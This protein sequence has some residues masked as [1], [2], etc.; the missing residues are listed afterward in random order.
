V[1]E[2]EESRATCHRAYEFALILIS[3]VS[4]SLYAVH[5][6]IGR[7]HWIVVLIHDLPRDG[8]DEF[9]M[10]ILGEWKPFSQALEGGKVHG[11]LPNPLRK[12][13]WYFQ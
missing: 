13:F 11:I 10:L 7:D 3:H 5:I 6:T 4:S 12:T 8:A 9:A 1:G 2:D